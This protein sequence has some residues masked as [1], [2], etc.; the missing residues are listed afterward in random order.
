[1]AWQTL[2]RCHLDIEDDG[3]GNADA[4]AR[5][6]F[7]WDETNLYFSAEVEDR[8]PM[9]SAPTERMFEEDCVELFIDPRGDDLRWNSPAD[10]QF[11]F[12]P[13]GSVQEWFGGRTNV[14]L[15]ARD[16]GSG[17][18]I[19]AM[20]PWGGLGVEPRA[21]VVL[22]ASPAVINRFAT[23]AMLKLNWHWEVKVDSFA[24]GKVRLE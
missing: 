2:D 15:R 20:L 11:G 19:D 23:N 4:A 7:A 17:Y 16:T 18:R 3:A 10:F 14:A 22:G 12:S 8:S 24:L 6:A 1:M 21:G 9:R 13:R 5:F